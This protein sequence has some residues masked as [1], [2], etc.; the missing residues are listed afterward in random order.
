MLV[1]ATRLTGRILLASLLFASLAVGQIRIAPGPQSNQPV[2][3]PPPCGQPPNCPVDTSGCNGSPITTAPSMDQWPL[4]TDPPDAQCSQPGLSVFDWCSGGGI[5]ACGSSAVDCNAQNFRVA[6]PLQLSKFIPA[7]CQRLLKAELHVE[8][9]TMGSI[10]IENLSAG[11]DNVSWTLTSTLCVEGPAAFG[12]IAQLTDSPIG[13]EHLSGY[14]GNVDYGPPGGTT[15][16]LDRTTCRDVCITDPAALATLTYGGVGLTTFAINHVAVAESV[17]SSSGNVDFLARVCGR[18]KASITYTYCCD[19]TIPPISPL[20]V[21]PGGT[22]DICLPANGSCTPLACANVQITQQPS[23]GTLTQVACGAGVTCGT[24]CCYRY[25]APAG[26]GPDSVTF[27]YRVCSSPFGAGGECNGC[28]ADGTVTINICRPT[29]PD[30]TLNVCEGSVTTS[31]IPAA[32]SPGCGTTISC[33]DIT[34]GMPSQGMAAKIPC[35]ADTPCVT[36][37]CLQ[38]TAPA[39]AT[40]DQITFPYTVTAGC[41][42]TAVGQV[43]V[44]F[45]R[46]RPTATMPTVCEGGTGY[47]C[48]GNAVPLSPA[49]GTATCEV[50]TQPAVGFA[51]I[52]S[53]PTGVTCANGLCCI[54]FDAPASTTADT[55]MIGYRVTTSGPAICTFTGTA[56]VKL[57]HI[58]APPVLANVCAGGTLNVCLPFT[59]GTNCVPA[60]TCVGVTLGRPVPDLGV[61]T[62]GTC[63]AGLPGCGGTC[64]T[65]CC[66]TFTASPNAIQP[67]GPCPV[68]VLIP[69]TVSAGTCTE[70]G[71]VMINVYPNPDAVDDRICIQI[72][73]PVPPAA[74]DLPIFANDSPGSCCTF[75]FTTLQVPFVTL[76]C[77]GPQHGTVTVNTSVTPP[78]VRYTPLATFPRDGTDSFCYRICSTCPPSSPNC[79]SP[80]RCCTTA[81]VTI[82]PVPPCPVDNRLEC[83]SLLIFPEYDHRAAQ[84]TLV[85]I[86]DGCCLDSQS[87][88]SVQVVF[89]DK[90]DC[91]ASN[92]PVSLSACDT[93]TF[94]TSF[95]RP[96]GTQGFLYAYARDNVPTSVNPSGSPVVFN[97]LIGQEVVISGIT[98]FDYALNAIALKGWGNEGEINDDDQDGI[99]DLN[100]IH[101]RGFPPGV[102][103]PE[104]SALPDRILVPRFLGQSAD[105]QSK[106]ILLGLSGGRLFQTQVA[107]QGFND[108]EV[109]FSASH[110]FRCWDDPPLTTISAA[111]LQ[112]SMIAAGDDPNEI[113]GMSNRESGWFYV[114]GDVAFSTQETIHDPAIYAVL[115]ERGVGRAAADLPFELCGQ[116]NGDLFPVHIFGDGPTPHDGDDQ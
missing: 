1:N 98:S 101:E 28:F 38:Y 54:R 41:S 70:T 89:V 34:L 35:P 103:L 15:I 36:G 50:T 26:A 116:A 95:L 83:G 67:G 99:R 112:T 92:A 58:E 57:C 6:R 82:C 13:L 14:D 32:A 64:G 93:V 12:T 11:Q 8:L 90:S 77:A 39:A 44:N 53:C 76:D 94:L 4:N 21:C 51:S 84:R 27:G 45:C 56:L 52:A 110:L 18:V 104:Y 7:P 66:L 65:S 114:D 48:I 9:A 42:C 105:V 40:T 31:C 111:F 22:V 113:V 102:P 62:S 43:I 61:A 47:V 100:V 75:D 20:C 85:T 3:G 108:D 81:R 55:V 33:A 91:S 86:T 63:P 74:V 79:M 97:H 5:L 2:A 109:T 60:P 87:T 10:R 37:C 115:V 73:P 59:A 106:L 25:T 24:S 80:S 49:C 16:A 78:I 72:P 46:L 23:F 69:Y 30:I 96:G 68:P 107:I 71:F 29:A 17:H 19:L 88:R